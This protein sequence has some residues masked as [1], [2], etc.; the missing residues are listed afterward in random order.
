MRSIIGAAEFAWAHFW[1]ALLVALLVVI[2]QA[3]VWRADFGGTLLLLVAERA[4]Q[5]KKY[6]AATR[7]LARLLRKDGILGAGETYDRVR[8]IRAL[9]HCIKGSILTRRGE[10]EE[11]VAEFSEAIDLWP[12]LEQ[13]YAR[14]AA[15]LR[16]HGQYD[17]ALADY[18][19]AISTTP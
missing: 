4:F 11:A 8:E 15:V 12:K 10:D 2:W 13:A 3:W 17:D 1:I 7:V 5:R 16:K 6:D 19:M 14:R 18:D 9:A